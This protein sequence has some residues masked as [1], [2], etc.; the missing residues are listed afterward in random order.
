[1]RRIAVIGGGVVGLSCAIAMTRSGYAVTLFDCSS[2]REAPSWG[3]AGHIATEQV[4]PLASLANLRSVPRR[5][6]ARGGALDLPLRMVTRWAPFAARLIA[7]ST[8][9]RFVAGRAALTQLLSQA[10]PAWQ[11]LATTMGCPDL[12]RADGHFVTWESPASAA[13]GRAAWTDADT[14]TASIEEVTPED[15]ARLRALGA[16]RIADAIRFRGSGQIADL[17]RLADALENTLLAAGGTIVRKRATLI[18]RDK[19]VTI[20]GFDADVVL[21]AAGVR[22]RELVAVAGH[23][24]PLVAERG[25]HIRAAANGWPEELPPVVF[26][27]RSMIVTRFA[28]RVQAAS[29]LELGDPDSPPDP[30]KWTRLEQHVA[31]LGLPFVGPLERWMGA[32]P[33]LPDYLPAIGR[34][35]RVDNLLYAFGHQHLGLTLAPVTA[36]L[37]AGLASGAPA[38]LDIAPFD[39]D[40]F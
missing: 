30:R 11:R 13:A 17:S 4:V 3:N 34:S 16:A 7:A 10:M 20:P 40:R 18:A 24:A 25:Y 21:V 37:I 23:R 39:L 22:S 15:L 6:F 8:P 9:G 29:F 27:D 36:E 31:D 2:A 26:E 19:R 12:V 32:R 14:G 38:A 28:D 5:L 35:R 33:T 1:M